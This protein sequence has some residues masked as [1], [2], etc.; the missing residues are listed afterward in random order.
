MELSEE[1]RKLKE[2]RDSGALTDAEF[3]QA[4][5]AVLSER[6]GAAPS[7]SDR[8]ARTSRFFKRQ[9]EDTLGAAAGLW[10]RYQVIWGAVSLV[11]ALV[12]FFAFFLPS[13]NSHKKDFDRM[14]NASPLTPR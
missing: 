5:A 1:I 10:V 4:K 7:P 2:L 11:L 9:P 13:W 12:F 8:A 3:A 6:T 14:G